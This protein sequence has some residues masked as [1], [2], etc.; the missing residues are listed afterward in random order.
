MRRVLAADE[1]PLHWVGSSKRDFLSFP[2]TVKEDM[3]NALGIAQFGGT[4]LTGRRGASKHPEAI[5]FRGQRILSLMKSRR[6][7]D[8][9][10]I[11]AVAVAIGLL[12]LPHEYYMLLRLFLCG[13]SVYYLSSLP[14]VRDSEK[15]VLTGLAILHNP[16]F[17]IELGSKL[18]WS[19]SN[20]ATVVCLWILRQRARSP[21]SGR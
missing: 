9:I 11:A 2:A 6:P 21:R 7:P 14:G 18:L 4:A 19:I 13:V 15:W 5:D 12:P 16:V 8:V 10:T 3:G 1:N 17:P 20:V